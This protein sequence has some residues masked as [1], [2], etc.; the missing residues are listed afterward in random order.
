M[1][2]RSLSKKNFSTNGFSLIELIIVITIIGILLAISI[3][4]FS[5]AGLKSQKTADNYLSK[6]IQHS[7]ILYF[8]ESNDRNLQYIPSTSGTLTS[9]EL[10]KSFQK[11][12]VI[13]PNS[14]NVTP[15]SYGPYFDSDT[16][17][18]S[19]E[20]KFWYISIDNSIDEIIVK[21]NDVDFFS[22][23]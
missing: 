8:N 9:S 12:I 2:F 10:I 1:F 15:G 20:K 5:N 3:N 19:K 17:I 6:K 21:A 22:L 4:Q 13:P 11:E 16:E 7:I 18:E 23:K 14:N